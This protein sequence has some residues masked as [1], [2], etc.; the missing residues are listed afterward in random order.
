MLVDHG[1]VLGKCT[2]G[3][4]C[5]DVFAIFQKWSRGKLK[6]TLREYAK[7]REYASEYASTRASTRAR[8]FDGP[9]FGELISSPPGWELSFCVDVIL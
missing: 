6:R 7:V 8:M 5:F 4:S 1:R 2:A 9:N 3:F